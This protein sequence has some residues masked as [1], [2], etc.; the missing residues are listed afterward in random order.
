[1]PVKFA[2]ALRLASKKDMRSRCFC[3]ACALPPDSPRSVFRQTLSDLAQGAVEPQALALDRIDYAARWA[4]AQDID[5]S[6]RGGASEPR[7]AYFPRCLPFQLDEPVLDFSGEFMPVP[8]CG[9]AM[10]KAIISR[11]SKREAGFGTSA[12]FRHRQIAQRI[13]K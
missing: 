5:V 1:M 7:E 10:T 13:G 6:E 2:R 4:P 9:P 8:I 12:D 11:L 3:R